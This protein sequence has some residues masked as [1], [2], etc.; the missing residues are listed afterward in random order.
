MILKW[1]VRHIYHHNL[2]KEKK[3]Y[4]RHMYH[5]RIKQCK[6]GKIKKG[7]FNYHQMWMQRKEQ[8]VMGK[9]FLPTENLK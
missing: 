7:K 4:F 2:K 6:S 5:I 9:G 8:F 3:A 1:R